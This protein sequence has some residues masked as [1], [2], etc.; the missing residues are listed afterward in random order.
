MAAKSREC[1][2]HW[3]PL[4]R[5]LMELPWVRDVHIDRCPKCQGVFLD[6]GEIRRITGHDKLHE[7]LT[8]HLG[9]DS[10]SKRVCPSCGM[11]MDAEDADGVEVDVCLSCFGVWLDGGEMETLR[12]KKN[13]AFDPA[14]FSPEKIAELE[15]AKHVAIA[16]RRNAFRGFLHRL[17]G[18]DLR[19]RR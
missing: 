1:P 10:D 18:Q 13:D 17:T 12:G 16:D 3:V 2:V 5:E 7:L 11:I 8:K 14:K 9:A 6:K 15:K 19:N 4:Q